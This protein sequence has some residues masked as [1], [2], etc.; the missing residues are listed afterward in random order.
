MM[1]CDLEKEL[2]KLISVLE[3]QN[4]LSFEKIKSEEFL[5]QF[6]NSKY[7]LTLHDVELFKPICLNNKMIEFYGFENNWLNGLDHLYYLKTIHTSTYNTLLESIS[8]FRK[9]KSNFLNLK[10]KLLYKKQEWKSVIGTTKTIL[11]K[12]NRKPKY[13]ITLAIRN[14][15]QPSINEINTLKDLTQREKEIVELL[16]LG[17][18]KKQISNELNISEHT[19]H[20]HSKNIYKKLNIGK[21][22]ELTNI[23][24]KYSIH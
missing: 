2:D 20:T 14:D 7:L 24:E 13:A 19:V 9:D 17:Y 4:V 22:S 5:T 12:D 3:K 18:S 8:F 6:N 21:I 23:V 15:K 16:C 11:R 10:Y 1:F